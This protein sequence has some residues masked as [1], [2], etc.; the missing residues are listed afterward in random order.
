W[1]LK[2]AHAPMTGYFAAECALS[3]PLQAL[4][5]TRG[6]ASLFPIWTLGYPAMFAGGL[7]NLV[8]PIALFMKAAGKLAVFR[9]L[10]I[11]A[12]WMIHSSWYV[13]VLLQVIP[14]EGHVP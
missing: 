9:R 13:F 3:L 8:L 1:A 11:I 10:R 7:A 2:F 4:E 6:E 14:R 5:R 12:I